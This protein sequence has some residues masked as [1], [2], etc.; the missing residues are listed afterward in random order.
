[1]GLPNLIVRGGYAASHNQIRELIKK[2][3]LFS[4]LISF[5][6]LE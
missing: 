5:L 3:N 6:N 2:S 1:M 4:C